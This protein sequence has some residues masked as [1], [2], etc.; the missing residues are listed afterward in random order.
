MADSEIVDQYGNPLKYEKE[1][2][3]PLT[4]YYGWAVFGFGMLTQEYLDRTRYTR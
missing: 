4:G 3:K 1:E 2:E